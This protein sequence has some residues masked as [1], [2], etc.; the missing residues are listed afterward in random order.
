MSTAIN[1]VGAERLGEDGVRFD[2][3]D[4]ATRD[5][6]IYFGRSDGAWALLNTIV[7]MRRVE[8]MHTIVTTLVGLV[9]LLVI[10]VAYIAI[11]K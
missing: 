8:R 4:D 1:T 6:L 7:L 9:A 2:V 3:L 5:K 10:L 11:R